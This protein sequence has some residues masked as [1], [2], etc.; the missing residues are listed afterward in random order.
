MSDKDEF[1]A[2]DSIMSRITGF[3][4]LSPKGHRAWPSQK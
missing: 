2:T 3:N 4:E 1:H